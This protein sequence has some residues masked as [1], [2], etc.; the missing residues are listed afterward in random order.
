MSLEFIPTRSDHQRS[1]AI[2]SLIKS[3]QE[4]ADELGIGDA[5]LYYGWPKFQDYE[6]VRH[7]VDLAILGSRVGLILIRV[8]D[9]PT[10][11]KLQ[12]ADESIS[13]AAASAISQMIKSPALR[14]KRRSL[15]FDITPILFSPGYSGLNLGDAEVVGTEK[16][17][18]QFITDVRRWVF[19]VSKGC[20]HR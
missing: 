8:V 12:E 19:D 3:L 14:S 2:A 10:G 7:P 18:L 6:A 11:R 5:V 4:K 16:A 15:K 1:P 9:A 17:I 20:L 13:Q